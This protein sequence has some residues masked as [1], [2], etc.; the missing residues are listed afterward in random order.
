MRR[1][2]SRQESNINL[3]EGLPGCENVEIGGLTNVLKPGCCVMLGVR[4]AVG[5]PYINELNPGQQEVNIGRAVGNSLARRRNAK[6]LR[7]QKGS[8]GP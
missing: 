4:A 1:V 7:H 8:H 5:N 3:Q 6:V 2:L